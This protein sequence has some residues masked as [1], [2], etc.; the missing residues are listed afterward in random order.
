MLTGRHLVA[1][2]A[3]AADSEQWVHL[4]PAGRF[5]G[6][7]GRGPYEMHDAA[8]V[9]EAT[10]QDAGRR[11]LPV[12]YDHAIDLA[13]PAGGQAIAA[14]WIKGLQARPN[15]IWGLVAWT[16]RAAAMLAAR[17]Y[18]Y[19]SP[20]FRHTE[21]GR[22]TRLL[23]AA[24]TNNPNLDLTALASAG[25][26]MNDLLPELRRLLG[27]EANAA[28]D[29]ILAAVRDLVEAGERQANAAATPDPASYV[30]IGEL[31]RV[32]AE[33]NKLRRGVSEQTAI[34]AVEAEIGHGRLP[35]FMRDW[36][37]SLCSVNK[38]AFDDF[39]AKAGAAF[40]PL[41]ERMVP[42]G[43][44]PSGGIGDVPTEVAARLGLTTEDL[45]RHK[46]TAR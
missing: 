35:P 10:R 28:E 9:I 5:A 45:R 20:V 27:L 4:L 32:T 25:G 24:L 17:E 29:A 44:P 36:G 15:G 34:A 6:R 1:L 19:L 13:A 22:V 33:L 12:D 7:D 8:A 40:K 23:R 16:G 42:G 26:D 30:P 46:E 3:A 38:P 31:V 14:G 11:Q 41:F 39:V 37:V 43:P 21:G 2:N 18:R